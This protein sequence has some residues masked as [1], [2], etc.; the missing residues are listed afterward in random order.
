[1]LSLAYHHRDAAVVQ[2]HPVGL[3]GGKPQKAGQ[4]DAEDN[5]VRHH[6]HRLA[7]MGGEKL[8][9]GRQA[10]WTF[11]EACRFWLIGDRL[12]SAVDVR[13]DELQTQ[14]TAVE[15]WNIDRMRF[16]SRSASP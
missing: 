14:L 4:V 16:V 12:G 15:R 9:Q 1:M 11:S 3:P 6:K 13:L 7:D 5:L 10:E 8:L 2:L